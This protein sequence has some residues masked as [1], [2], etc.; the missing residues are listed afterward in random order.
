[1]TFHVGCLLGRWF[2][3]NV[4]HDFLRKK[5]GKKRKELECSMLLLLL[6]F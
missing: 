5:N 2:I 6:V 1:M 4:K 3:G